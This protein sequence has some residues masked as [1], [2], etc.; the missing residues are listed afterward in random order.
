MQCE[1]DM[2]LPPSLR[3]KYKVS[4]LLGKG[5]VGEVRLIFE[6]TTCR[7]FAVKK[8]IKGSLSN[9]YK[10]NHPD[11]IKEEI[12]ILLS[13]SHPNIIEVKEIEETDKEVFLILEYMAGGDLTNRILSIEELNEYQ[14][15][16]IFFQIVKAVEYL[17]SCDIIHRDLKV[18]QKYCHH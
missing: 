8:I 10:L 17:H 2:F 5:A 3:Q 16:F 15:K 7:T 14:V 1:D 9:Y 11:K 4:K 18:C 12:R 6:T 13:L